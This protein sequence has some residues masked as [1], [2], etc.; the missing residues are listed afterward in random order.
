MDY[1]PLAKEILSQIGSKNNVKSITHCVT[2]VRFVLKDESL[3]HDEATK[4]LDG[5]LDVVKQGG[6]YQVVIGP[7][8]AKVY[9]AILDVAK[10]SDDVIN[11]GETSTSTNNDEDE[12]KGWLSKALGLISSIFIP[13]LGLLSGAGMIKAV[14]SLCTVTGLM[15]TTGG[16]YIILNALGDTLFY[17]FPVI[18]G[19]SAA[20]RF[21]LKEIYG[22]TLGAFL[23]YPTL[24]SAASST[25]VTTIFKGTIFA[26]K[27]KMTF[28][29][30]PVALQSYSSTVI[31]IIIIVWFAS[32]VYKYCDK[33]IPDVL[34]MV[35]V[36]F[37][38]LLIAGV[39]SLIIIGPIAM[40]LQNILSD[41][42]LW[43]VGL[44]KGVAGFFLG[45]FW[46]ILVMFG[47]HW[48]VIPF[49]A[50]DIAHYGYDVIN[51][52]IFSGAL[53][54]L[55]ST[56]GVAIRA[57][58][59]SV[60]SMSVAAAISAFFGINEPALYGVLIP[61]KRIMITSFLGA[62]IGGAIAGF[63]G[64][65]LYE[66]GANGLLGLPCFI[67]PKG[68][69]A[70]FIGLCI[71]GIVAFAFTLITALIIG[72]NKDAKTKPAKINP[73]DHSDVYAPVAGES[74]DLTTV[75]DDV[76]SKLT[77]GDGIA[78]TPSEGK[79]YAPVSGIIRVAYP[80]GHAVGLASDDGEE[81]LIHIGIDTV[82]LEGKH[83]NLHVN[84][85]MRVKK[86]DLLVDFDLP[87]IQAAGY[88][89][90]V[91][92]IVTKSA[93]L[94]DVMP[95]QFGPVTNTTKVLAVDLQ[96]PATITDTAMVND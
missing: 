5:V 59:E 61:R 17:F 11:G 51:P 44:N 43:L 49:F 27:Y 89:P 69:D 62:G 7:S 74:F 55:G 88:D 30:I 54:V 45:A 64:S 26:L 34:K 24:V 65:K 53:A 41:T 94:K 73:A 75:N 80:T 28:M 36:P 96:D 25:A 10:F 68:I 52:L 78:I 77:L 71:S 1:K 46:S 48:A 3:A 14:V 67:N 20:K 85:G 12:Q 39:L 8:V 9:D 38:T 47:L 86:G 81:L 2:R 32:Y 57:R 13:V 50:I 72:A 19:W 76:F 56:L 93:Q 40:I 91:M 4:A 37:F 21:G 23:V 82:N 95:V 83:F 60:R 58:E 15:S 29:G 63:A 79:V 35:F 84:Q 22:V 92:L 90:T 87:A 31:P 33:V 70:G 16:T 42:V 6:Q 66:F 18:I